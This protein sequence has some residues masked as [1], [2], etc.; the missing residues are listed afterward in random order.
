MPETLFVAMGSSTLES[1][2]QAGVTK[3]VEAFGFR[4]D[5]LAMTLF[6]KL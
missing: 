6:S 2:K 5:E 3:V 1:I 4:Q